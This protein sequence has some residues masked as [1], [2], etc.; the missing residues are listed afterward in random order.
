MSSKKIEKKLREISIL[1]QKRDLTVDEIEKI[2]K[3]TYYK[4]ILHKL[5]GK[6]ILEVLPDEVQ[7]Y[8][9]GFI[10]TNTRL[11]FL[12][13]KYTPNFV[14]KNLTLLPMNKSTLEKL[15]SCMKYIKIVFENSLNKDSNIYKEFSKQIDDD[16]HR[17]LRYPHYYFDFLKSIIA[18]GLKHY[19]KIYT[20]ITNKY[21]L[22]ENE[23]NMIKLFATLSSFN[24]LHP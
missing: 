12:R 15:Y 16:I 18:V 10:D 3:E 19:G 4:N 5:Y 17:I 2:Q 24:I 21:T 8:I 20:K 1:K 13:S 11:K 7:L 23:I 22:R 14:S 6:K 9:L